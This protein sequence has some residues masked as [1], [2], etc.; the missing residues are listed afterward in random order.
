MR[1]AVFDL[2]GT[3]TR[4]DTLWPYLCAWQ[5]SHPSPGFWPGVAFASARWLLHRDH[6]RL[7]SRL[8]RI[9]MGG[10]RREDV[11]AHTQRF[12]EA[13]GAA[14]LCPGALA[15]IER[16]RAAGDRLVLLSASVDL[17]VPAIA[18]RFGFDEAVCTEIAWSGDRLDGALASP[19]RRAGEKLRCV[20]DLRARFPGTAFTA[21]G[22]A[23]TDFDHFEAVDEAVLANAGPRLRRQ[24]LRRGYRTADWR[25]KPPPAAVQS[26]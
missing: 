12:V 19:N 2:D 26:A 6:G 17:Y 7:K 18:R 15:A 22:N 20:L 10:T 3:L 25:N 14:D 4:H 13:L 23:R 5:R 9:A 11:A 24:A 8:I 16:H 21:Y 1:V